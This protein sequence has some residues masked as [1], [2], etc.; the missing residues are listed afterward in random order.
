M[1][2]GEVLKI[3]QRMPHIHISDRLYELLEEGAERE[4]SETVDGYT[5]KLLAVVL[6]SEDGNLVADTEESVYSSAD[7]GK[8]KERLRDLGYIE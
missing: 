2:N 7:E 8:I 1:Y 3:I 5:E 4:G 6:K